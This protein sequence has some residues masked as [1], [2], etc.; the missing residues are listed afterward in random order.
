MI[1]ALIDALMAIAFAVVAIVVGRPVSYLECGSIGVGF[2]SSITNSNK[3]AGFLSW[4]E[5]SKRACWEVK[6]V[7]GGCIGL[8]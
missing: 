7:W 5:E 2:T 6:I 4:A 8:R 3:D 1:M